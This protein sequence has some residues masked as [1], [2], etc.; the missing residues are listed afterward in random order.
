MSATL[1]CALRSGGTAVRSPG[2]CGATRPTTT[3]TTGRRKR[4]AIPLLVVDGVVG[5]GECT[6]AETAIGKRGRSPIAENQS[7]SAAS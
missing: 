2:N 5:R 4:T 3:A 6:A 7:S 1:K